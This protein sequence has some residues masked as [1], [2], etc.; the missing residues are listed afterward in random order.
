MVFAR[1]VAGDEVGAL[2]LAARRLG[3]PSAAEDFVRDTALPAAVLLT[4]LEPAHGAFLKGLAQRPA[5]PGREEFPVFVPG[6]QPVRP[7]TGLL[8]GRAEQFD[9]LLAAAREDG[10]L[11]ALVAALEAA[12]RPPT[13]GVAALGAARLEWGARTHLMGVVNVTPDSFSDGGRYVEPSAAIA[14]G[15]AL[16][17]AGADLLDVGGESTRPGA[18]E[19]SAEDEAARV[20]PVLKGL[21]EAL[22]RVP[23]SVDTMKP[24]VARAALEA[25]ACLVNDV[26]GLRDPAMI[27][28]AAKAGAAVCIMH[29]Q[30]VPRTMQQA[31]RYGDVVEEVAAAL[32]EAAARAVAAGIPREKV[33]VDPGIG[34]GKTPDHNLFLLRRVRDLRALGFPVLVGTSRKSVLGH[35]LG[36]RPAEGRV[37]AT[38][39]SVAILAVQGGA[40]VVRVHDVAECQDAAKVADA[41]RTARGGGDLYAAPSPAGV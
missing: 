23:L 15:Q 1:I 10:A 12:L 5:T 40:D 18:A 11:A 8:C 31:P 19:V 26:S 24:E 17:A 35:V 32:A 28:T 21:R 7:G 14:H 39:A 6:H 16:V 41:I 4:G 25:G 34:F 36:G 22:P 2:A 3:L 38:A 20:L 13:P 9:R 29:M 30:G 27:A 33:L 37:L